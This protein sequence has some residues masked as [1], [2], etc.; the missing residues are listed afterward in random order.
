M[1]VKLA[2]KKKRVLLASY[3]PYLAILKLRD[4]AAAYG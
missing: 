4:P 1:V 3:Q 2:L